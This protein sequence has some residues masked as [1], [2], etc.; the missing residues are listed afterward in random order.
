MPDSADQQL[1]SQFVL[2]FNRL[3]D[4]LAHEVDP[5]HFHSALAVEELDEHGFWYWKPIRIDTHRACLDSIYAKLPARF[6]SLYEQLVLSYRW[7]EVD[8]RIFTLLANPPGED[9]EPLLE[10]IHRDKHLAKV[11]EVNGFVRF[12][13]G[14]DIDYDPVCFDLRHRHHDGDFRIVK[15]D[16]EEILC[17]SRIREVAELASSFRDLVLKTIET[18]KDTP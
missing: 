7:A 8:L 2:T 16:H 14:P 17:H 12:G 4:C 13:K 5:D 10:Q 18:A 1:I 3:S 11:L 9:L 6:P 15:L